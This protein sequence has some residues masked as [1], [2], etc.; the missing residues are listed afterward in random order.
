MIILFISTLFLT[1]LLVRI[2]AHKFHDMEN[3]GTKDDRSRTITGFLRIKTGKDWH[4]IHFGLIL[5]LIASPII[6]LYGLTTIS[7]ILLAIGLSLVADQITPLIDRKS[8]YFH[9]NKLILSIIFHL[10]IAG[11]AILIL[12]MS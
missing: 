6:L 10:I 7:V 12:P 8:N 3:Y 2:G 4:H 11:I 1:L 5:L 9:K